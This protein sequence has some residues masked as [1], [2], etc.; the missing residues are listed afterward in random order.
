MCQSRMENVRIKLAGRA[1]P[2]HAGPLLAGS[3]PHK[4]ANEIADRAVCD[5]VHA[6]LEAKGEPQSRLRMVGGLTWN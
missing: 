1:Q 5:H 2:P 4:Q 6:A 3:K